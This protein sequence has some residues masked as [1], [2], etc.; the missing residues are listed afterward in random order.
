MTKDVRPRLIALETEI[1]FRS[2]DF[3]D[4]CLF[5][6]VRQADPSVVQKCRVVEKADLNVRSLAFM[7]IG[8]S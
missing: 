1:R 6:A 4:F 5:I 7:Y 2:P 8:Q 3:L